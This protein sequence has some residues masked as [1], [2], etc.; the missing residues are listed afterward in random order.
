MTNVTIPNLPVA[1]STSSNDLFVVV[2]NNVTRRISNTLLF[3]DTNLQTPTLVSPALGTPTSGNLSNCTGTPALT[4]TKATG[5]P[6]S[7]GITGIL[8]VPNGGSGRTSGDTAYCLIATG[9]TATGAQQTLSSGG[10]DQI[11]VGGGSAALPAWTTATGT[12]KPVREISPSFGGI[13]AVNAAAPTIASASTIVPVTAIVFVSGT[14]AI[15]TITPTAALLAGGGK[16]IL[17]PTGLFTTTTAGNIALGSTAVVSK[18]LTM[19]YDSATSKWY[20][21]Y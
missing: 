13:P 4:L 3:T 14:T 21:S 16:V 18:A 7:T 11:L 17:I 1:S 5:L 20:P 9:T 8:S 10:T 12:G 6:L 19:V 15:D 2:Q